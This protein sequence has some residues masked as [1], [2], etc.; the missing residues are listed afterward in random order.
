MQQASYR[1][2][3]PAL[4]NVII[5]SFIR[6]IPENVL[7]GNASGVKMAMRII[8]NGTETFPVIRALLCMQY[9]GLT[10]FPQRLQ[11][12]FSHNYIVINGIL[13]PLSELLTSD[14][15]TTFKGCVVK[16]CP[17]RDTRSEKTGGLITQD[18]DLAL[19]VVS[20]EDD[21][22]KVIIWWTP[23]KSMIANSFIPC[24]HADPYFGTLHPGQQVYAEGMVIF[25][26][27]DIKPLIEYLKEKEIK[28][29]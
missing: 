27:G 19:S 8:N 1:V 29:Y 7:P 6:K 25:A 22:R 18:M 9:G 10:G 14:Q 11:N 12:N 21:K 15:K 2:E 5:E 26:E 3:S 24:I 16:G 13:T 4:R 20:S 17:Q 23:G 28:A